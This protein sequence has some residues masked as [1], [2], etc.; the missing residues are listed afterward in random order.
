MIFYENFAFLLKNGLQLNQIG[1]SLNNLD[2][3]VLGKVNRENVRVEDK[4][5]IEYFELSED[6]DLVIRLFLTMLALPLFRPFT[7]V[8]PACCF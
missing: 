3:Y 4:H 6:E 7:F 8:D 1:F 2:G 5:P